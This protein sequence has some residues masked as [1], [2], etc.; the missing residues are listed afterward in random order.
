[1]RTD[2]APADPGAIAAPPPATAPAPERSGRRRDGAPLRIA[3]FS[4]RKSR[5]LYTWYIRRSLARQGARLLHIRISRLRRFLGRRITGRFV[6]LWLRIARPDLV[7]VFSGDVLTETLE[8][9][10]ERGI[11]TA[12]LL[13]DYFPVGDPIS[14][15]IRSVDVFVHTMRGQLLEHERAGARRA[16][17]IPSGVDAEHHRIV[18]AERRFES[19]C[20]FIGK[21][22]YPDRIALMR[23]LA[24]E[25]DLALYGS[26]WREHGLAPRRGEA[27]VPDFRRICASARIIIGID[28]ASDMELYFSNRTWFTL[29]C[30]GF[31]LTRYVPCLEEMFANHGHLVWFRD[32]AE[33]HELVRHYLPRPRE[34]RRIAE[35]GHRFVHRH[36]PVDRMAKE[37]LRVVLEGEDPSPL[38]DPHADAC[39]ASAG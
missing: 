7:M 9:C 39:G 33:A 6:R 35:A 14:E 34:R 31:L 22:A 1:M 21:A 24:G 36:Y 10:R 5:T 17:F 13:D 11:R 30:G 38:P 4:K 37:I 23:S 16:V 18:P 26:G 32:A 25:F 29:G 2:R 3:F 20:A 15:K 28:K 27:D 12:L 8:H 19:D